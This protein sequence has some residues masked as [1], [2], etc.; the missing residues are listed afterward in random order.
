MI[1]LLRVKNEERWIAR[2]VGSL[3]KCCDEIVILDD[4]SSDGT[5]EIARQCG[6]VVIHSPFEGIDEAR[7]K[8]WLV[9]ECYRRGILAAGAI[10]LMIDG[11]EALVAHHDLYIKQTLEIGDAASLRVLYLWDD[12]QHVR[13]DGI[14]GRFYRPSAWRCAGPDR[15][16]FV[17]I[18]SAKCGL[19]CSN[20]PYDRAHKAVRCSAVLLHYGYMLR[21]DRIRKYRAYNSI[22]PGNEYEDC[23][24]HIVIG[25][26][27]P[28]DSRFRHAGP[29][30]VAP[31][32]IS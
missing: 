3:A 25:D 8:T 12:E 26:L 21:D 5:P 30:E 24:R 6:A 18:G 32:S 20:V 14:Y 2:A 19:H 16:V 9:A 23:Y 7:D 10:A 22:D 1:G 4:H 13:L 17:T 11:D 27:F 31:C 29:L 15:D 28:A